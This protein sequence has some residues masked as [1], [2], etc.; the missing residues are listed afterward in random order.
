MR[1]FAPL[2]FAAVAVLVVAATALPLSVGGC[3]REHLG[4]DTGDAYRAA[5]RQQVEGRQAEEPAPLDAS[6]AQAILARHRGQGAQGTTT[7]GAVGAIVAA[8]ALTDVAGGMLDAQGAA[9][10]PNTN[11]IRLEAK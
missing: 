5:F 7:R 9:P 11:P 10:P 8:P 4:K 6:D 2:R 1:T 3:R